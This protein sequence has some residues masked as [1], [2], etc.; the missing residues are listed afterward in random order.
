MRKEI[1]SANGISMCQHIVRVLDKV[2]GDPRVTESQRALVAERRRHYSA[3]LK[4]HQGKRA[5]FD[6][7]HREATA[8]LAEANA[9]LRRGKLT[10]A[11]MLLRL[12]PGLLLRAY[13]LRDR[14]V[15]RAST[16]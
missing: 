12:T 11:V 6:G 5:F 4:L 1:Q 9:Y 10:L 15:F 13:D 2:A 7:D 14:L 8:A 3:L 16:R